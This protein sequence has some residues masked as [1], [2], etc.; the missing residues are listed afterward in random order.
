MKKIIALALCLIMAAGLLASCSTLKKNDGKLKIVVSIFPV[1]DWVRQIVGSRSDSVEI[2]LLLDKGV[3]LHSYQPTTDDIADIAEA[4]L[5]IA[6]GGESDEWI[7]EV[8]P[9]SGNKDLKIVRLLDV[10]GDKAKEEELVEGM[11]GEEEEEGEKEGPEYDEHVWLSLKNASFLTKKLADVLAE[12]DPEGADEY[13]ANA[14]AYAEKLDGLDKK[15]EDAV[16]AAS[17]KTLLFGDRFPFRYMADDYGL[18]YYAA[19]VGC[20]SESEASFET[21]AFLAGKV[22]ELGLKHVLQ[23]ETSDGSIARTVIESTKTKDQ[24]VLTLDS[25]QNATGADGETYLGIMESNL[26]VLKKALS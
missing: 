15:Y 10:L 24:D 18:T 12:T 22:D 21:I 6:V 8:V 23:I 19:F 13:K 9:A 5:L 3:D 4:D 20:S 2:S 26:K 17:V 7:D 16:N 25:L 1:Y 11:Q 14:A